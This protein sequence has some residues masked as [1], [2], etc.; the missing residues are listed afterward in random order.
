MG[1]GYANA[2]SR[3]CAACLGYVLNSKY[4]FSTNPQSSTMFLR[5]I[6]YWL[7]MTLLGSAVLIAL[8]NLLSGIAKNTAYL[9]ASKIA[10][11]GFLFMVSYLVAK[12]WVFKK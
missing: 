10:V 1:V 5:F 12:L 7:G 9:M 4:T 2:L 6:L 11:E 8:D 3:F